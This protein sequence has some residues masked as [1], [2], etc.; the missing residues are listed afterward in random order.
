MGIFTRFGGD[1]KIG[2]SFLHPAETRLKVWLVPMVPAWLQ[3]YHLT[4]LTIPWCVLCML[5]SLFAQWNAQWM[6]GVSFVIVLQY[7]TDLLD[8]EIGRQRATGLIKWGYYMDHFLDYIFLCSL[9]IGYFFVLPKGLEYFHFFLLAV[10]GA[11]MVN[12]FLAF[13]ATNQFQISYMGIGP[14]EV[15]LGFIIVNT[16]LALFGVT[17]LAFLQPYILGVS[18][19]G[20]IVTV[21]QTQKQIWHLDMEVKRDRP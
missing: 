17:H 19:V 8:G 16:L 9:L 6:W 14:T 4:L 2:T 11:Y 18:L 3:T 5:F 1:Q 21:C 7:V 13:A 10:F 15:R 20:L 12:S